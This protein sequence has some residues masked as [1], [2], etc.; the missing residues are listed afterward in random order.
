MKIIHAPRKFNSEKRRLNIYLI[1]IRKPMQVDGRKFAKLELAYDLTMP[2]AKRI[3]KSQKVI[4]LTHI[5]FDLRSTCVDM[6]LGDPKWWNNSVHTSQRKRVTKRNASSTQVENLCWLAST[7]E[8]VW[9]AKQKIVACGRLWI[10]FFNANCRVDGDAQLL[11]SVG[12]FFPCTCF[13][14]HRFSVKIAL[15]LFLS[16]CFPILYQRW[17]FSKRRDVARNSSLHKLVI[18]PTLPMVTRIY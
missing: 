11:C 13:Y 16:L 6:R 10:K 4:N 12:K 14:L 5:Q 3:R 7:Y 9:P 8:S 15:P 18:P 2:L 17:I 1:Q